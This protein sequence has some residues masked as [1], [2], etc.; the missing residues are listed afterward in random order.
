MVRPDKRNPARAVGLVCL[1]Q[2]FG[3]ARDPAATFEC[4][5]TPDALDATPAAR[6]MR[7]SAPQQ[8]QEAGEDRLR[9]SRL[10]VKAGNFRNSRRFPERQR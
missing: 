1:V 2:D 8:E 6:I 10:G 3:M 9:F 5:A 7:P 4:G